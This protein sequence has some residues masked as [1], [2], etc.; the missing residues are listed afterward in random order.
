MTKISRNNLRLQRKRR[1][2]AK[3]SGTGLVPRLAVFRS[4][5]GI[6]AQVI[7]DAKGVTL[8]FASLKEV[9]GKNDIAGAKKVGGEVAKKC[10]A[11]KIDRVVFDRAGYKY[12]GKIKAL[13]DGAR[14][15][16]LKF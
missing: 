6:Q 14:E 16:G 3:I 9:K 4:L 5:K 10:L 15:G 7:D 12:H 8:A 2:R 11:K 1:V 13:A